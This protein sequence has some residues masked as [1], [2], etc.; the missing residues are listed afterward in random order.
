MNKT[1]KGA[2]AVLVITIVLLIFSITIPIAWLSD[3]FVVRIFPLLFL[4]LTYISMG[5]SII[6]L[7]RKQSP[8]E[9]D[10][11]E[12]DIA[13]KRKAIFASYITLWILVF[14]ACTIPPIINDWRGIA[15]AIT[16]S[17][18][19]VSVL[20][21]ALFLMFIIVM[22]VYA[23]TILISYGWGDKNGK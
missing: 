17:T 9:V 2:M 1:Q 15:P 7:R 22:L 18:I 4:A 8:S 19:S 12:R 20:P 3:M 14:I 23:L 11:D 16:I 21:I 5:L 6:L 10:Y 13:I